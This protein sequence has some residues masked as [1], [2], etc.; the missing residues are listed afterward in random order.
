[1]TEPNGALSK[2]ACGIEDEVRDT[3]PE[4]HVAFFD[5]GG[6]SAAPDGERVFTDESA[7]NE[8]TRGLPD[9]DTAVVVQYE[10]EPAGE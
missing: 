2:L 10:E 9:R 6:D 3:D 5:P 8:W 7:L 1:M 4:M